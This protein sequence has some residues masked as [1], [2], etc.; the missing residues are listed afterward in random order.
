MNTRRSGMTAQQRAPWIL[1]APFLLLFLLTFLAPIAYAVVQSFVREERS[2]LFGEQGTTTTFA[3]FSNYV[4]AFANTEFLESIGR[5]LLFGVVQVPVMIIAATALAL[6]LESASARW[7][8][9]FRAA[10]FMPYGVPGVIASV[11]WSFLYVP[12][13]SPFIDIAAIVGIELDFLGPN[14]VLWSIANIVTWTYTGYNMLIIIAQLKAIP[15][16]V[17]EA[18]RVDGASPWRI[19]RSIQLPLITPALT[20]T[21]I[22]SIIGTIQLFAEPQILQTVSPAI[23]N[24]YTPNLA[25][26]NS[27][28]NYNNYNVAAA[29]AVTI[30]LTAF[31]LSYAF[32]YL[33][34]R[35]SN[36]G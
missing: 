27:A 17:Y 25:A 22:F 7:P 30:A 10:Y 5:V 36:D 23:G 34:N 8:Q 35:R 13:L 32:L 9:F 4:Q 28:F 15:E 6:L 11:L 26:Y 3:G 2:G 14:V 16:D 19:A 12:G 24:E 1:L 21:T 33:S 31:V 18:A 20:L 29:Q